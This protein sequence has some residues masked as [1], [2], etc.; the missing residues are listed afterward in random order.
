M[1]RGCVL[2]NFRMRLHPWL[3]ISSSCA[4]TGRQS[5]RDGGTVGFTSH[6]SEVCAPVYPRDRLHCNVWCITHDLFLSFRTRLCMYSSTHGPFLMSSKTLT[7][8]PLEY[9]A[10]AALRELG[11]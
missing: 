9:L 4:I 7:Q 10:G 5:R 2:H 11:V 3:S 1:A 6:Y 8:P